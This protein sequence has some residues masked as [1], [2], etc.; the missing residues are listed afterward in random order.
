MPSV[1]PALRIRSMQKAALPAKE[2]PP[3][4][5]NDRLEQ[6][7]CGHCEHAERGFAPLFKAANE[8]FQLLS[9]LLC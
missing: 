5:R 8:L 9:N 2:E 4:I 1:A 7:F 3:G 6:D